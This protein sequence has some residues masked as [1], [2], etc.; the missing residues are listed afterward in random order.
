MLHHSVECKNQEVTSVQMRPG[1]LCKVE[2][3]SLYWHN[4]KAWH[5]LSQKP[6]INEDLKN[7]WHGN[8]EQHHCKEK[9]LW[10][11][12]NS[13]AQNDCLQWDRKN[14]SCGFFALQIKLQMKYNE[15]LP[16]VKFTWKYS[17]SSVVS[18]KLLIIFVVEFS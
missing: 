14:S 6:R 10:Q 1:A 11:R 17:L 8:G 7:M 15:S 16:M 3:L 13:A 2:F 12:M 18:V 4:R 5:T 9:N